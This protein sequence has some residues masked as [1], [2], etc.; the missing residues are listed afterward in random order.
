[1]DRDEEEGLRA[2]AAAVAR[3]HGGGPPAVFER[4][5]RTHTVTQVVAEWREEERVGYRLALDGG[6]YA[7]LYYVAELD[8]WSGLALTG[9][10]GSIV[11]RTNGAT[12]EQQHACTKA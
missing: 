3:A 8:L 12:G 10:A 7:L 1:M 9:S 6:A 11:P 2:F 4:A 5:G